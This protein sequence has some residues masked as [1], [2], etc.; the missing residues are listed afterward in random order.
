MISNIN[1][2][3]YN[4]EYYSD[5]DKMI[6]HLAW[7]LKLKSNWQNWKRNKKHRAHS[8]Y[9][10]L[11]DIEESKLVLFRTAQ[12]E[13]YPDE[14]TL[15]SK[16]KCLT[17][18]SSLIS[19]NPILQGNLICRGGRANSE[20]IEYPCKNQFIINKSL[21]ILKLIIKD[22]HEKGA[23]IGREHTLALIRRKIWIPSCR[24]LIRKVLFDC[25][26]CRRERIKPQKTFMTELPKERLDAYEKSFYNTG[27][28]FFGP[29][30][31]KLSKK[32]RAN[33]AKAKRYG[34]IFTCTTRRV[35]HLEIAG[36]LTT[37][38]LIL[39]LRRFIAC[40]G[41]VKHIRSDNGTTFKGVQK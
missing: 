14:Y 41:N 17:R 36:D 10:T 29:L 34:V 8:K 2:S 24:G 26:Y 19:L 7:I 20:K 28:D 6:K 33:Q 5:L 22:S 12:I 15:L 13:S 3:I 37:D 1:K 11:S 25:L 30:I 39:A 21:P 9:L 27:I 23:H 31:V 4:W 32:T 16:G 38:S 40:R 35:I 18:N